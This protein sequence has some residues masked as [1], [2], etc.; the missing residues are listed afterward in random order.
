VDSNTD[1]ETVR[2]KIEKN[3]L[4]LVAKGNQDIGVITVSDILKSLKLM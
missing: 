3:P 4:I 1:L 2:K